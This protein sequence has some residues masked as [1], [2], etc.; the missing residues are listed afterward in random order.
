MES[1]Q[2]LFR[3]LVLQPSGFGPVVRQAF[4]TW[5]LCG[6]LSSLGLLSQVLPGCDTTN[7]AVPGK[8]SHNNTIRTLERSLIPSGCRHRRVRGYRE[9][10]FPRVRSKSSKRVTEIR[11]LRTHT[12]SLSGRSLGGLDRAAALPGQLSAASAVASCRRAHE[13][14]RS[15][16]LA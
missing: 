6:S 10:Y 5:S 13:E 2:C 14:V 4:W 12:Q 1:S 3:G 16:G 9:R 8:G 15:L 7:C 11:A